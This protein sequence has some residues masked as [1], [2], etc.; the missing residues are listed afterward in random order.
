MSR[1]GNGRREF[2]VDVYTHQSLMRQKK[3]C[4]CYE[5]LV[6]Q[7]PARSGA[8][9]CA[10]HNAI[11]RRIMRRPAKCTFIKTRRPRAPPKI[12]RQA[13][14]V[15][16]SVFFESTSEKTSDG[17]GILLLGRVAR[18]ALGDTNNTKWS[19]YYET[20]MRQLQKVDLEWP[21]NSCA[22]LECVSRSRDHKEH[23]GLD[24]RTIL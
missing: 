18:V 2:T 8:F 24:I 12:M 9:T 7:R 10:S 11:I 13:R 15:L 16:T 1:V 21:W 19:I 6:S 22:G 20:I 23:Q 14:Q 4:I 5:T 17:L 3:Q